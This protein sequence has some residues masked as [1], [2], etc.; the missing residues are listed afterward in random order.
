MKQNAV[1][2]VLFKLQEELSFQL[3]R[4]RLQISCHLACLLL[5]NPPTKIYY[6]E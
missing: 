3:I 2:S 5:A 6:H 1:Y 4:M